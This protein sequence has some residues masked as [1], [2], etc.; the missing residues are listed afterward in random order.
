MKAETLYEVKELYEAL[1]SNNCT[2]NK[3]TLT[4]TTLTRLVGGTPQTIREVVKNARRDIKWQMKNGVIIATP[5]GYYITHDTDIV[6]KQ[7]I[8]LAL[9]AKD[10]DDTATALARFV[11]KKG[12]VE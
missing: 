2:T 9:R 5:K 11:M 1:L 10:I 7:I 12:G 4:A 3:Q 8:S 6:C